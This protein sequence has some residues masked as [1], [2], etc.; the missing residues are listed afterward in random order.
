MDR[1]PIPEDEYKQPIEKKELPPL[2]LLPDREWLRAEIADVKYQISMFNGK[3]QVVADKDGNPILE[4]GEEI[5]R[6]EFEIVFHMADYDMPNSDK[7]RMQWLR[8]G[9]SIGEKAHL[10]HF[11]INVLGHDYEARTPQEIVMALRG[12]EVLL[13]LGNKPNKKDPSRPPYQNVIY[14]A[15]KAA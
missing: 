5:Y 7:P 15:V 13:Q 4:N 10:P 6:R 12:Q 1:P 9:A 11:L 14:D 3:P 2:P 8:M